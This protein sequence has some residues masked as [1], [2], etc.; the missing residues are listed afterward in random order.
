MKTTYELCI[1]ALL[2]FASRL[3]IENLQNHFFFEFLV[4]DFDFWRNS[5]REKKTKMRSPTSVPKGKRVRSFL[6]SVA[7]ATFPLFCRNEDSCL[8]S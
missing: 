5:A 2:F 7:R 6:S 4:F 3:A 8:R 1:Q